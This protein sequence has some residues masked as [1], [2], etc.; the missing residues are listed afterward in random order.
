MAYGDSPYD[1]QL[2]GEWSKFCD[3]LKSAGMRVFKDAN[4]AT[5]LQRVDGTRVMTPAARRKFL[6]IA[7]ALADHF[8][9]SDDRHRERY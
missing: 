8:P 5:A 9:A 4:P 1:R 6:E 3:R 2:M 7:A